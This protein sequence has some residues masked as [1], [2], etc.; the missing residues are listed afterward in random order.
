M[1]QHDFNLIIPSPLVPGIHYLGLDTWC[2]VSKPIRVMCTINFVI[3][4]PDSNAY[5]VDF[6]YVDHRKTPLMK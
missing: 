3:N 2:Q 6:L 4:I 1:R 5:V